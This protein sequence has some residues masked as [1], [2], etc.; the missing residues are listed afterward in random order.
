MLWSA[1]DIVILLCMDYAQFNA[2]RRE[3]LK[4]AFGIVWGRKSCTKDVEVGILAVRRHLMS[5]FGS[6]LSTTNLVHNNPGDKTPDRRWRRR[7]RRFSICT[8]ATVPISF[9]YLPQALLA[10]LKSFVLT[11]FCFLV[12]VDMMRLKLYGTSPW[13]T[14]CTTMKLQTLAARNVIVIPS[15][16]R[17]SCCW[18]LSC[19]SV[20]HVES[21]AR[22]N[23]GMN[24]FH[25]R[26][27]TPLVALFLGG[28]LNVT[29][30]VGKKR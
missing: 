16:T 26:K 10:R 18:W 25:W 3:S 17:I 1:L 9:L 14:N 28:S 11:C 19:K 5:F 2:E 27:C 13:L 22:A 23:H 15:F 20:P 12:E 24:R 4:L 6:L 8:P 29:S 21:G 7:R 30:S